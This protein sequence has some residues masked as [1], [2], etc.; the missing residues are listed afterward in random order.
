MWLDCGDY[1][2]VEL[3]RITKRAVFARSAREIPPC[4]ADLNVTVDGH[5]LTVRV[6][7]T[8]GF[9]RGRLAARALPVHESVPICP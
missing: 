3:S 1:G 7:L 4:L 9:R 8:K 2:A 6:H 5:L